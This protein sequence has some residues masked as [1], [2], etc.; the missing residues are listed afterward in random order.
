MTGSF[1]S[2][3]L[4]LFRQE[5]EELTTTLNQGLVNLEHSHSPSLLDALMRAAHSIKGASRAVGLITAE[6]ISHE[7]EELLV[8]A[9][10]GTVQLDQGIIDIL[11]AASDM[12]NH[13]AQAFGKDFNDWLKSNQKKVEDL[14]Q[15]LA[16][17]HTENTSAVSHVAGIS[18]KGVHPST[19]EM[20]SSPFDWE[21]PSQDPAFLEMFF[22]ELKSCLKQLRHTLETEPSKLG[23]LAEIL[24]SMHG[25]ALLVQ[26]TPV[27]QLISRAIEK[28]ET[29]WD[30]SFLTPFANQLEELS[31]EPHENLQTFL[32]KKWPLF[33][34]LLATPKSQA[35]SKPVEPKEQ[36]PISTT[37]SG[38]HGKKQSH[39]LESHG[40]GGEH[41]PASE[42]LILGDR[43]RN[44]RRDEDKDAP[45]S[46]VRVTAQSLTRLMGLAGESLVEAR[47]LAPFSQSLLKLKREQDRLLEQ[48]DDM[49]LV[50]EEKFSKNQKTTISDIREKLSQ[51]IKDLNLR[52][53]DFE[54]H[55]RRSDDL[56]SRLYNEVITSR[57]RPFGDG[58]QSFAR[59]IRDLGRD[60]GKKV[61]LEIVGESTPVDRDVLEKLDAPLTHLL[62]NAVDHGLEDTDIRVQ[63]GKS[64][65][66]T[67]RLEVKHNSGMLSILVSDD[68]AGISLDKIREKIIAKKL[69]SPEML[70]RMMDNEVLDFLFLPGFSTREQIT[71]VSGRGVGLDIVHTMVTAVGGSVRISS[72]A[73]KG[74]TFHL[75]LP[76]TLSVIRAVLVEIAGEPY[77]FP[78]NRIER[79]IKLSREEIHYLEHRQ[80]FQ[81][82]GEN[83][84][85]LMAS[86]VFRTNARVPEGDLFVVLF[87]DQNDLFGLVVDSFRGEQ[88]LVVRSLDAR[89]GKVPNISAAAILDD[90]APVLIVDVDDIRRS[91]EKL[92]EEDRLEQTTE[93]EA[94][95]LVSKKRLLIVDDS[96]TVR[97][98]EKQL[99]LARGYEVAVAVDG[100]DGW[101]A[102]REGNFD[103]VVTDID[104]PRMNGLEF[105]RKIKQESKFKKIPVIIVS[106]KD[107]EEDRFRGL[108]AGANHYLTKSSFHDESLVLAIEKLIGKA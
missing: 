64:E 24:K 27:C 11:L 66:G 86:Q 29:T 99:L 28:M 55:A 54:N 51:C 2:S 8:K 10:K 85:L 80:Y 41:T 57:M 22:E 102:L 50:P 68:G 14:L 17:K 87:R 43:R 44:P 74:T 13:C 33:E 79:L 49:A 100:M 23:S 12:V 21:M 59:M 69:S 36:A 15:H 101:N 105:T 88:D 40:G 39:S 35:I 67:V 84:G 9:Q 90:G 108:E 31:Q 26:I 106:H 6:K 48:M 72:M 38:F 32:K 53:Q 7:M 5:I 37:H 73:S 34:G 46:V 83:V 76:L 25:A 95:T 16:L 92:L 98:V 4:G 52:V 65:I 63:N 47:W 56:N 20:G 60:L 89:L 61:L 62:R 78:H 77:A 104:M 91:I 70:S 18:P 1:D 94:P 30:T 103:L 96:I 45:D 71:E 97:E 19:G 107:R 58:T 81:L 42:V 3:L 93:N 82:D 75:Q